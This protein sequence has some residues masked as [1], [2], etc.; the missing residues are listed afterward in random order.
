VLITGLEQ[1]EHLVGPSLGA[2][3]CLR[4]P[5]AIEDLIWAIECALACRRPASTGMH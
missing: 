2:S 1:W 5:M 4:K 3:A